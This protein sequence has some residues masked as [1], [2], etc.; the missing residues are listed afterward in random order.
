[1]I[2]SE[3]I[4][5]RRLLKDT[6]LSML[7]A[8]RLMLEAVELCGGGVERIREG[9]RLATRELEMKERSVPFS[10]AVEE[11]LASKSHRRPRTLADIRQ[12]TAR[13]IK[14]QPELADRPLRSFT[15][16]DCRVILECS[17]ATTRQRFKARAILGGI[18]S[19]GRKR[20]WCSVNPIDFVDVP[21]IKETE[22]KALKLSEVRN[23][24]DFSTTFKKGSCAPAVGLMVYAG[25]R[26]YEVERL[27]WKDI[28]L[29]EGIVSLRPRHTKTGGTRHVTILPVLKDW[30]KNWKGKTTPMPETPI[31]PK[32]W[33]N[34]WKE[35]RE[36]AG[37][38]PGSW[39]EDC[40]R[41][42]FASYHAK[43]FKDYGQL[44]M[45]MGHSSPNLLRTRY[46]NM[47]GIT[48][49]TASEFWS[50]PILRN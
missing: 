29:D 31:C 11:T 19:V 1:M 50:N 41:H 14:Q 17:F 12:L 18:F 27:R 3:Y 6:G 34:K 45:E 35:L 40:L 48:Q 16:E 8:A 43:F 30:L 28:N 22:V 10:Q 38:T 39:Q 33:R 24:L 44:Q 25:I 42:T 47:R 49:C 4:A 2:N 46:L 20:G 5:A 15:A 36:Q 21:A 7:D 32:N 26:P 37:W 9:L 13:I 23:L